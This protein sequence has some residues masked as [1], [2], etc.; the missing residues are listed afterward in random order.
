MI[1][2]VAIDNIIY[3]SQVRVPFLLQRPLTPWHYRCPPWASRHCQ[4]D[5]QCW[6]VQW[7][8]KRP[9]KFPR[10]DSDTPIQNSV[11]E[12]QLRFNKPPSPPIL[13]RRSRR[14]KQFILR[15]DSFLQYILLYWLLKQ[16]LYAV[17]IDA[18]FF[19]GSIWGVSATTE[20]VCFTWSILMHRLSVQPFLMRLALGITFDLPAGALGLLVGR[21]GA[22]P[23]NICAVQ[24]CQGLSL[25][26]KVREGLVC[27]R[28]FMYITLL[29]WVTIL[30]KYRDSWKFSYP[31][32]ATTFTGAPARPPKK[33][34]A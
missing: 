34:D 11:C 25:S 10:E 31:V 8:I 18:I 7:S 32:Q 24:L 30:R 15:N 17:E 5:R 27:W 19:S 12:C 3:H 33:N 14:Y 21:N 20:L 4:G 16:G 22:F 23:V 2:N 6:K 1:H 29:L 28:K 26:C 9:G 13:Y